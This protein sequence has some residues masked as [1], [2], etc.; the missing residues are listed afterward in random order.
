MSNYSLEIYSSVISDV[1]ISLPINLIATICKNKTP[2]FNFIYRECFVW[3]TCFTYIQHDYIYNIRTLS[4][5]ILFICMSFR[6]RSSLF[7]IECKL[8]L[9]LTTMYIYCVYPAISKTPS[10]LSENN[11]NKHWG[12]LLVVIGSWQSSLNK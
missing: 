9:Y 8:I 3:S 1:Y 5:N 12:K 10:K 2:I 11:W 6:T 7:R 4:E